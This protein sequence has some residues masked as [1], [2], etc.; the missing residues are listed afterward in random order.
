MIEELMEQEP[1]RKIAWGA[2]VSPKFKAGVLW[3]E[4][5]LGLNAD[6]L[7]TCMAFETGQTFSPSIRNPASSA[8]GL[9]QFMDATIIDMVKHYPQL[10]NLARTTKELAKL[11]A[12]T[13]LTFVYYYF[14]PYSAVHDLSRWSLEDCYMAILLPVMIGKSLDAPMEWSSRA[15]AANRGLDVNKDGRI[16]KREA[17]T[18]VRKL[19]V[20]GNEAENFG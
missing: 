18:Y 19:F 5:Q 8:T 13:Q 17:T 7:M 2:R 16:T 10:A 3:I 14:K 9:I 12:L 11:P 4:Q 1:D 15:Y 20:E 6:K